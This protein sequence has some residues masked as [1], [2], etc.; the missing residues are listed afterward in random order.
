MNRPFKKRPALALESL[1]SRVVPAGWVL[2][3]ALVDFSRVMIKFDMAQPV[4]LEADAYLPG[5]DV[6][7]T[8]ALT[9]GYFESFISSTVDYE[10]SLDSLLTDSRILRIDQNFRVSTQAIPN[11]PRYSQE[12][13]MNNSGQTGGVAGADIKAELAWD[14]A[15]GTGQT[16]VAVVD[17]GVDYLHPDL[18]A[19]M[20]TNTGEIPRNNVDD[21]NNGYVDDYYGYDTANGDGDPMDDQSHGTHVSGTIGAVGNNSVGVVGVAWKTR[22]MAVKSMDA[23]GSGSFASIVAGLDYAAANG[24][25]IVNM[26]LGGAG[27]S[28]GDFFEVA[29]INAGKKGVIVAAAA[30]NNGTNNDTS[31]FYPANYTAANIVSVAA[32]DDADGIAGFSNYGLVSIDIGAPGV[33]IMSTLPNNSYGAQNGTSMATPMVAG[34]LVVMMDQSPGLTYQQYIAKLYKG[35]DLIP[36]LAGKTTTG[37]RLNLL[38]ALPSPQ[39]IVFDPLAPVTYGVAPITLSAKGGG[40]GN[41]VTF[42]IISGPGQ[43]VGNKLRV[44]GA[45]DIVIETNQVGNN[46]YLDAVPVRQTLTVKQASLI[47][48]AVDNSRT[49]GASAPNYSYTVNG[50]VNGDDLNDLVGL[51]CTTTALV[52]SGPGA[53]FLVPNATS[54]NYVISFQSA[55]LT[56]VPAPLNVTAKSYG[57]SYGGAFPG[58]LDV[59]V[60]GLVLGEGQSVINGLG[61]FTTATPTSGA[62]TY[63][64]FPTGSNPNYAINLK[65]GKL[66]I[67]PWSL[68][69]SASNAT[70]VFGDP[71]PNFTV[72]V[73]GLVNGDTT[74]NLQGFG[75][76]TAALSRSPVGAYTIQPQAANPN[77]V[78]TVVDAVLS[79]TPKDVIITGGAST[80]TYGTTPGQLPYTV[81]GLVSP[82][83][84]D[85]LDNLGAGTTASAL[86]SIGVYPIIASGNTADTN[87]NVVLRNGTLVVNP[88]PLTFAAT[89]SEKVYGSA[90][91]DFVIQVSG[92]V[93][94]DDPSQVSGVFADT[95]AVGSSPV[96]TYGLKAH[97]GPTNPNYT[98]V[99][100][101]ASLEITKAP[102]FVSAGNVKKVYGQGN[103][104]YT[105]TDVTGLVNG[106]SVADLDYWCSTQATVFSQAGTYSLTPTIGNDNYQTTY[107]EGTLTIE[108]APLEIRSRDASRGYGQSNPTFS[109]TVTGL[110]P[111]DTLAKIKGLG[112]STVATR[113]SPVG[114]Y[115]IVPTGTNS[116][117][118]IAYVSGELDVTEATLTITAL[119]QSRFYGDPNPTFNT[120][121][122]GLVNGDT[123]ADIADLGATSAANLLSNV[124]SYAISPTGDIANYIIN[125]VNSAFIINPAPL[126]IVADNKAM[127][128]RVDSIPAFTWHAE[129]FRNGDTAS[130]LSGSPT[131]SSPGSEGVS[132]GVVEYP[133]GVSLT[134]VS[135]ANYTITPQ[136]G[137]LT[138]APITQTVIPVGVV[139]TI[140]SLNGSGSGIQ[141]FGPDGKK[142]TTL[143]PYPGFRG[144]ILT[145]TADLDGDGVMDIITGPG[146]GV[147]ANIKAYSGRT[148]EPLANFLAYGRGFLGGVSLAV[149]DLDGDGLAEILTGTGPG[150]A[151]HVKAFKPNGQIGA[152]FYAY[153]PKFTR[154]VNLSVADLDGDGKKE[155]V[156]YPNAGGGPN[157]KVFNNQGVKQASFYAYASNYTGG[158]SLTTGDTNGDG[159]AEIITVGGPGASATLRTFDKAGNKLKE[160][161]PNNAFSGPTRVL[162]ADLDGNGTGE[163]ITAMGA[164][165]GPMI[166]S[167]TGNGQLTGQ[168]F[169]FGFG[170]M[171]GINIAA[172]SAKSGT[173]WDI[174]AAPA[175]PGSKTEVKRFTTARLALV[176][177]LFVGNPGFNGG[178]S[179]G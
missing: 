154:G 7:R 160:W 113:T 178:I 41:P 66:T 112:A 75:A 3:P 130:V 108:K 43:M 91:P 44:D 132:Q 93:N 171:G 118:Q 61:V 135:S 23:S 92:W 19:N 76:V 96:G 20:W 128:R 39:N 149:A 173:G 14:L 38:K 32:T 16:V 139:P 84:T 36:S 121:V 77:Y 137:T 58:S 50:F 52:D 143:N 6:E 95:V 176:D 85:I 79:V 86:S 134:G 34:A 177:S 146:A 63:F 21:D 100:V 45:G 166:K 15:K 49:Y 151:P 29:I 164:P 105:P 2:D 174:A 89:N 122:T 110:A 144:S 145:S 54:P 74:A 169:A 155:I 87:Y 48:G 107:S 175:G 62:G 131:L 158:M 127:V 27:G 71:N 156:T 136:S 117:Y 119:P 163:I 129:G 159:K 165:G 26:S 138:V 141:A 94:N 67:T 109:A 10:T 56:I 133:I 4:K 68:L 170:Y 53:Y 82:D 90:L 83:T 161:T 179:L 80:S 115:D 28:P 123:T 140:V 97:G 88:A 120:L 37:A 11:D 99:L 153:D 73:A 42:S 101:D 46:L 17:T 102:L 12:W 24:A 57:M 51:T 167:F 114:K 116:N 60:T 25:S 31:P 72:N 64:L 1:E 5:V 157:V 70:R 65:A 35:A 81:S 172:V 22:I 111:W 103:P 8:F 9:P 47:L 124:G 150:S 78:I 69:V 106:D 148:L 30:G 147:A 13:G 18:A 59:T 142:L 55:L 125:R 40:S 168:A 126:V 104:A 152:S 162:V 98:P 33:N